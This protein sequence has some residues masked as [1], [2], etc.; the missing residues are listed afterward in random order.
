MDKTYLAALLMIPGIGNTRVKKLLAFFGNAENAWKAD[1]RD[2]FLC[3]GLDE[4]SRNNLLNHREKIDILSL[5]NRWE[6]S[7]IRLCSIASDDYPLMLRSTFNAPLLLFYRGMLPTSEKTIAIVGSRRASAYGR[8]AAHILASEL[9]KNG[10]D[11]VSGAARGIDTSAHQGALE[12][13]HTYAV[14]GCGIDIVYPPENARL[15]AQISEQ[16]GLISEYPPGTSPHAGHFPARNRII[17]GLSCGVIVVE[18]A[19]RSGALITADFALEEG[20]DVFAVPGSIFNEQSQGTN[21]LIKQGAKLITNAEDIME[22]YQW[23]QCFVQ[24][25]EFAL[26]SEEKLVYDVLSPENPQHIDEL[27]IKSNLPA[28]KVTYLLLQLELRGLVREDGTRR[29]LCIAREGIR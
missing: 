3:S 17:N 19:E 23:S 5:A 1:R 6:K 2:L 10:V 25:E 14:L 21:R 29:Y 15:L 7:G 4:P 13:G 26:S 27:I 12:T 24:K 18:A 28:S 22:E 16:G 20:R 11:I 8:N 9:A